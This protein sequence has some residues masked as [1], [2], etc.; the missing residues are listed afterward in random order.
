MYFRLAEYLKNVTYKTQIHVKDL[1]TS[2][3]KEAC[4]FL[5]AGLF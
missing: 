5:T 2:E 3:S 1:S 4:S